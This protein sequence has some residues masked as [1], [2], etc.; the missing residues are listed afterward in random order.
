MRVDPK[1]TDEQKEIINTA[2]NAVMDHVA[3]PE[4][5]LIWRFS[6]D[7]NCIYTWSHYS[8]NEHKQ[9]IQTMLENSK[10]M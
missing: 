6:N 3:T 9:S 1:L 2:Y 10:S 5:E 4:Q 7:I 8:D